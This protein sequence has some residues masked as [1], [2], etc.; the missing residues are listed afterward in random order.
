MKT[1]A[2]S[3][4]AWLC[5]CVAGAL[6]SAADAAP[7]Q[8]D[9]LACAG[10]D[11]FWIARVQLAKSDS[12]T[13]EQ[14]SILYREK[15]SG[16]G[17]W[18]PMEPIIG[19]VVSIA[20][21]RGELLLVLDNGQWQI[22]DAGEYRAGP[23]APQGDQMLAIA[24]EQDAVWAIVHGKIA[25][26]QSSQPATAP[27]LQP[28]TQ[29][30]RLV[31]CRFSGGQWSDAHPLPQAVPAVPSQLSLLVVNQLPMLAWRSAADSISVIEWLP[32]GNWS[33]PL[34]VPIA[35]DCG[36]FEL[37][38]IHEHPVLW[39]SAAQ[40]ASTRI[41]N[42][43]VGR[44]AGEMIVVGDFSRKLPLRI[45]ASLASVAGPQT[46]LSAFGNLRWVVAAGDNQIEQDYSLSDFPESLPPTTRPSV[47]SSAEPA[48]IPL[49]PWAAGGAVWIALAAMAALRQRNILA[50]EP[51]AARRG[52]KLRLAS[53]GVRF[54]AGLVDLGPLL[55]VVAIVHPQAVENPLANAEMRSL[56]GLTEIATLVYVLHT[57]VAELIC[58]QSI[59]KMIFGLRV[60]GPEGNPPRPVAVLLRNVMRFLDTVGL[61]FPLLLVLISP[62]RQRV[63]DLVAGTVVIARD[64]EEGNE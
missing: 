44:G 41:S 56:Q 32:A 50:V 1:A 7:K 61:G 4:L 13:Y 33:Q 26:V 45:P 37:L 58:G 12:G 21:N 15:W 18:T 54:V 27:A 46:V 34:V 28:A 25:P 9:L 47:V 3:L 23:P 17:G 60:V 10:E 59:G 35:A 5:V 6:A 16:N 42:P 36:D 63:G 22:A 19:R 62:L 39:V 31:A 43:S 11:R 14:T 64:D 30:D 55:I 20:S 57:L 53:L 52:A 8:R 40:P 51:P 38:A 48:P 49:L 24:D 2:I 29:P